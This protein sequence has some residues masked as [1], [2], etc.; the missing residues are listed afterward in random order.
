MEG[1]WPLQIE[2]RVARAIVVEKETHRLELT[3]YVVLNPVRARTVRSA[4]D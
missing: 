3:R 4:R 2:D 1:R